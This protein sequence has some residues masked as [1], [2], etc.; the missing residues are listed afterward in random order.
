[1]SPVFFLKEKPKMAI[2]LSLTLWK[3]SAMI[4]SAKRRLCQSFISITECQ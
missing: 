4:L 2:F 1:M 3:S